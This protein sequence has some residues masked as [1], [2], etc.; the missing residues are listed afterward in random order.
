[1]KLI[2]IIR[3]RNFLTKGSRIRLLLLCT[4]VVGTELLFRLSDGAVCGILLY[5]GEMKPAELFYAPH[6]L[7]AVFA[8][9]FTVLRYIAAAPLIYAAAYR[10]VGICSENASMRGEALSSIILGNGNLLRSIKGLLTKKLV[11]ALFLVPAVFFGISA[12][13]LIS[14]GISD[15]LELLLCVHASVM[16]VFSVGLW[17]WARIALMC[18]PFILVREP[19][20][21]VFSAVREVF[22]LVVGRRGVLAKLVIFHAPLILPIVTAPLALSGMF[23]AS[24]LCIEIFVKEDAYRAAQADRELEQ[25]CPS[26]SISAKIAGLFK[27]ASDKAQADR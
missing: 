21:S 8:A 19:D 11:S 10:A 7:A 6:P 20:I 23:S 1:M 15:S 16:T 13:R 22:R 9:V 24:A 25:A 27:A 14:H 2:Q 17:I 18:L 4:A 12:F 26:R 3:Y 5:F